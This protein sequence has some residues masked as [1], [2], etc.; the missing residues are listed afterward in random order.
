LSI[1]KKNEYLYRLLLSLYDYQHHWYYDYVASN[2]YDYWYYDYWYY[3]YWY[4]DYSTS[5]HYVYHYF[6]HYFYHDYY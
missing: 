5:D 2:H 3:D 6:Y 1:R 4:Y